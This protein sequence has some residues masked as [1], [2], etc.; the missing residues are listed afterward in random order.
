MIAAEDPYFRRVPDRGKTK[1][2]I[3]NP[4]KKAIK[5]LP[6]R[7]LRGIPLKAQR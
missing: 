4:L 1:P 3:S 5:L 2:Q 7:I 6:L